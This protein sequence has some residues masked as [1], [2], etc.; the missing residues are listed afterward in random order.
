MPVFAEI[1]I[2]R[3]ELSRKVTTL[4]GVIIPGPVRTL[5]HTHPIFWAAL[6]IAGNGDGRDPQNVTLHVRV[7]SC[8]TSIA[9]PNGATQLYER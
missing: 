5:A 4:H 1:D 8:V 7:G 9:G 6:S 2:S 3:E